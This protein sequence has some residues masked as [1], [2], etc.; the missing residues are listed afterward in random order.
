M[1][2]LFCTHDIDS[3]GSARSLSILLEQLAK[4]HAVSILSLIPPN[5]RKKLALRYRELGIP[6]VVFPWGWLPVSYRNCPVNEE[7]HRARCEQLRA[8]IPQV[9]QLAHDVDC[10]CF[11]SYP[12]AGLAG[13]FPS[14]VP[15]FLIARD[16]MVEEGS[17]FTRTGRF[18]SGQ[19][20]KAVA[21]GPV[22]AAQLA[23]LGIEH[24]IVYNSAPQTPQWHPMPCSPPLRFGV[25]TQFSP[26]KGLDILALAAA[27]AAADLR[28]R[29]A[30]IHV[31]GGDRENPNPVWVAVRDF[32]ARN[33][34]EDVLILEG[35]TDAVEASM[36][37]LH[38]VIRPDLTGSPWGRDVLEAMSLGRP[39]LATGSEAVFVKE[40]E[41]GRLVPPGDVAALAKAIGALSSSPSLLQ[42]MGKQAHAFAAEH[43]DPVVN[44]QRIEQEILSVL[45]PHDGAQ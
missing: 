10:I 17:G 27:E 23:A 5:P 25:F 12:A 32:I 19:I 28:R 7:V 14:S 29:N 24:S 15:R 16:V 2:L 21:I 37:A 22:E 30:A 44:S 13:L 18:L 40:G 38:C 39:V 6:L 8:Y 11:N 1:K 36:C 42:Q 26:S 43:F 20:K 4:K 34:L 45:Q 33:R 41:T 35:W 31:Y 3:G 9:R